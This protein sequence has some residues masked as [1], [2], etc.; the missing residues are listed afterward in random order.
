MKNERQGNTLQ[1]T[2]TAILAPEPDR[3]LVALDDAL[4]AFSEVAARQA[5]VDPSRRDA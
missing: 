5:K 2:E 3:G 1:A 4:A